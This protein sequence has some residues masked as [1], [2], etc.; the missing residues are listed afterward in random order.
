MRI[1]LPGTPYSTITGPDDSVLPNLI[2]ELPWT[3][4]LEPEYHHKSNLLRFCLWRADALPVRHYPHVDVPS[5][6]LP[7]H[8]GTYSDRIHDTNDKQN[9]A[10]KDKYRR[11]H[12]PRCGLWGAKLYRF[13]NCNP[14]VG[15]RPLTP[16]CS[17]SL[18]PRKD[19]IVYYIRYKIITVSE[20]AIRYRLSAFFS[21]KPRHEISF[22]GLM[23]RALAHPLLH[24]LSQYMYQ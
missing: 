2:F 6:S 19:L 13:E 14:A 12:H 5:K 18:W 4:V 22:S 7:R 16:L 20:F 21:T 1:L 23:P 15:R 10:T 11:N 3:P 24:S 17:I 8:G 9:I